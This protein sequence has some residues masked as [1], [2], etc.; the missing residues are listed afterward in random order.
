MYRNISNFAKC[1]ETE[2]KYYIR[3]FEY[4]TYKTSRMI[5]TFDS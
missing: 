1:Y 5:R 2:E 3:I 4:V